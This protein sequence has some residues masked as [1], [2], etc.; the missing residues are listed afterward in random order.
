MSVNSPLGTDWLPWHSQR[1]FNFSEYLNLNGIFNNYGFS[2]WEK[3]MDLSLQS[4]NSKIPIYFSANFFSHLPYV[5]SNKF[6]GESFLK[7]Y[8]HLFDKTIILFTGILITELFIKLNPKKTFSKSY[9]LKIL[10]IFILF[11]VNPWTYKMILAPWTNIY[12][13]FFFLS[14]I[15]MF[16]AN[17]KNLGL[18]FFFLG[19]CFDYQS[20][21]GLL[22]YYILIL[23]LLKFNS[24]LIYINKYYAF[25]FKQNLNKVKI[26]IIFSAPVIIFFILRQ[27]ASQDFNVGN[28]VFLL[29]RIG[30]NGNDINNGGLLGSLQF[31]GGNRISQCL[32]NL[33]GDLN[34]IPLATK[35]YIFNCSLS[36]LSMILVSLIS[37]FGLFIIS[38]KE[39][40]LFNFVILPFL[41]LLISYTFILQ[42]SSSVHLMG[43]SYFFS[44][45]FS[46]GLSSIIF[47]I[48]EKLKYSL[49]SILLTIPIMFG[50]LILLM[51]VS[52]LTG[53]N[54]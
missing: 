18:I 24:K 31:L 48:L 27:M 43:Y 7:E 1:I 39:N 40:K 52:M 20:S 15:F 51:R 5:L 21:A 14:G 4:E 49:P 30:L 3:D 47:K 23:F 25:D 37:T 46:F 32:I 33:K 2:I 36:I 28:N 34:S 53:P 19:G 8:W 45:I 35:I 50:I 16:L 41:F 9:Q 44:I 22:L 6:F 17:R 11:I 10:L 12:F 42:Q 13:V 38:K 29:D 26:I 54:G